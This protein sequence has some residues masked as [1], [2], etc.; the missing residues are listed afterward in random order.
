MNTGAANR[1]TKPKLLKAR[2]IASVL[3]ELDQRRKS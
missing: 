1:A 3:G 2:Q